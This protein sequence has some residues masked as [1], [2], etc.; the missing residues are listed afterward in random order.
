MKYAYILMLILLLI[1]LFLS[2]HP[3]AST[4]PYISCVSLTIRDYYTDEPLYNITADITLSF[5]GL[6]V[7]AFRLT[8]NATGLAMVSWET[9]TPVTVAPR[10]IALSLSMLNDTEN[11]VTYPLVVLKVC[12][13]ILEFEDHYTAYFDPQLN[14]SAYE[15]LNIPLNI[16][17]EGN[18]SLIRC[19][20]WVLRGKFVNISNYDP[21]TNNI[22]I[23]DVSLGLL[24]KGTGPSPTHLTSAPRTS[25]R[26]P[27]A[28]VSKLPKTFEVT[29][30]LPMGYPVTIEKKG[31]TNEI[32]PSLRVWITNETD[33]IP[34]SYHVA[35]ALVERKLGDL[36]ASLRWFMALGYPIS[37]EVASL[38]LINALSDQ[39]LFLFEKRNYTAAIGAMVNL[40]KVMNDSVA[41]LESF[42]STAFLS[43]FLMFAL[44]FGFSV[45]ITTLIIPGNKF[46]SIVEVA[47]FLSFI[48]GLTFL[49]PS[50]R[51]A[52]AVL[53][54]SLGVSIAAFDYPV[55][56][57]ATVVFGSLIYGIYL[58]FMLTSRPTRKLIVN[59]AL[60]YIRARRWRSALLIFTLAL[61]IA[62]AIAI[63]RVSLSA[64]MYEREVKTSINAYGLDIKV[65]EYFKLEGLT[66]YELLWIENQMRCVEKGVIKVPTK[67][68]AKE[69]VGVLVVLPGTQGGGIIFD[70]MAIKPSFM[71]KYFHLNVYVSMGR[72]PLDGEYGVLLPSSYLGIFRVGSEVEIYLA[73]L[74]E[75]S[76][77]IPVKLIAPK[78]FRVIGFYDVNGI[79]NVTGPDGEPLVKYPESTVFFPVDIELDEDFVTSRVFLITEDS[80]GLD[81]LADQLA[82][83]FPARVTVIERG[84]AKSYEHV[85][86]ITLGGLGPTLMLLTM[87]SLLIST[88]MLD[89]VEERR[90]DYSTLAILGGNPTDLLYVLMV[91]T[92]IIGFVSSFIGWILGVPVAI[93]SQYGVSILGGSEGIVKNLTL[94]PINSALV[95][96]FLGVVVTFVSSVVPASKV[97]KVSLMGRKKRKVVTPSDLSIEG[98]IAKYLLPLRVSVFET[99]LLYRFL[100]TEIVPKKDFLGE[101]V[102]LD[103]TFS[104]SFAMLVGYKGVT[105]TCKL[106]TIRRGDTLLVELQVPK[107]YKDYIHFSDVVYNIETKILNYPEW[108]SQQLRYLI[109][110]RA[111][112]EEVITLDS[113]LDRALKVLQEIED[114][115]NRLNKL[116]AMKHKISSQLYMEYQGKYKRSLEQLYRSLRVLG[117]KLEPFYKQLREEISKLNSELERLNVAYELGE[118]GPDEYHRKAEPLKE[119]LSSYREKADK[120]ERVFRTL[121]TPLKPIAP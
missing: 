65:N 94:L 104:I 58:L 70:A 73:R 66:D 19:D 17:S 115:R 74:N 38:D 39:A 3:V 2:S 53:L 68:P 43:S 10:L 105:V 98:N 51:V 83:V 87:A 120:V 29:Y 1:P 35:K 7:K 71:A 40:V 93:V 72:F 23:L 114:M 69:Y 103:G 64:M 101:E 99:N 108:K 102:Y 118:M 42:K 14:V 61:V 26:A 56:V 32:Y 36:K 9:K 25:R 12:K 46:K 45:V 77:P 90:R 13:A 37:E 107:E 121:R 100:K 81:R 59:L 75:M 63:M 95:A 24:V 84:L 5:S 106:K 88:V 62:S 48:A 50:A 34:W 112:R 49:Q 79:R 30:V 27:H 78:R 18:V 44:L 28:P 119:A 33:L 4:S 8:T 117:M 109:L 82:K 110:R 85:K 52:S 111:P 54:S 57:A 11:N 96:L 41:K 31:E 91:E 16:V 67:S 15:G 80:V 116:E 92:L 22:A 47:L 20:I 86:M 97:Q 76:A 6:G 89:T 60:Q 113:L 21:L 55:L